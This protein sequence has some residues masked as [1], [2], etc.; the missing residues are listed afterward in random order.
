MASRLLLAGIVLVGAALATGP[1]SAV[2]RLHVDA[3]MSRS[4][5]NGTKGAPF[6]TLDQAKLYLVN[7]G[8][9]SALREVVIEPGTYAP[10]ELDHPAL[11]NTAWIGS[12]G[13][14][15]PVISGGINVPWTSFKT[16]KGDVLVAELNATLDLGAM[17]S[18]NCVTDCQHDKVSVTVNG[19]PLVLARWPNLEVFDNGT[20]M[21]RW[22]HAF[23]D[24]APTSGFQVDTNQ[25]PEAERMLN[26]T[27]EEAPY[28]HG[29]WEWDW[30]DWHVVECA[31]LKSRRILTRI[32][33][34]T[35]G[36][37]TYR[38]LERAQSH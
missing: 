30:A 22:S 12:P 5:R 33:A 24:G 9:S 13:K 28:V 18:G 27:K 15:K 38:D 14:D 21:P 4:A 25:F 36:S 32:R 3:S 37:S 8:A 34:A 10:L 35:A 20:R 7:T 19:E 1:A 26:W 16:W 6:S 29:Y 23:V 31:R 2:R 17:T 11:S